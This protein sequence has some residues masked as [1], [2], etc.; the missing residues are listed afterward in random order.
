MLGGTYCQWCEGYIL[1]VKYFPVGRVHQNKTQGFLEHLGFHC[2]LLMATW[3][4]G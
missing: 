2:S 3:L 4:C 1:K